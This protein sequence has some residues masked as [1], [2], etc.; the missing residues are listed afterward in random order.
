VKVLLISKFCLVP[1]SRHLRVN[2][3]RVLCTRGVESEIRWNGAKLRKKDLGYYLCTQEDKVGDFKGVVREGEIG[4][5]SS[6]G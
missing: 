3:T 1:N 6:S 4:S 2:N 5:G